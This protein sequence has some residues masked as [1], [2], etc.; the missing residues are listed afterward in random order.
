MIIHVGN[1]VEN[2]LL[3][4]DKREKCSEENYRVN[5][6]VIF[7]KGYAVYPH[8]IHSILWITLKGKVDFSLPIRPEVYYLF[9]SVEVNGL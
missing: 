2:Y 9:F 5:N 1:I 6:L 7:H 3:I 4:V 8:V